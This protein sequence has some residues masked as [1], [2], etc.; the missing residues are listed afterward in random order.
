MRDMASERD[1]AAAR[2]VAVLR[3]EAERWLADDPDARVLGV[4]P[5]TG[6]PGLVVKDFSSWRSIYSTAPLLPW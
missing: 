1:A 4:A 3:T 5:S 6:R 2:D